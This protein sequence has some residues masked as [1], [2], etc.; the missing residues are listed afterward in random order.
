MFAIFTPDD[1][2]APCG[3]AGKP[4]VVRKIVLKAAVDH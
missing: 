3:A 1:V 2:H 4:S